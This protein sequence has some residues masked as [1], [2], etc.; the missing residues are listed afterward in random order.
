MYQIL[1]E[2]L[3]IH[4]PN[5]SQSLTRHS[6]RHFQDNLQTLSGHPPD[7]Q[8][9]PSKHSPDTLEIPPIHPLHLS[10]RK[11][12]ATGGLVG[13]INIM[14]RCGSNLQAGTCQILS[15]AENQRWS[16]VWKKMQTNLNE[17]NKCSV[18]AQ[19]LHEN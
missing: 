14:P 17:K 3:F 18:H 12:W 16:L 11:R 5:S 19:N 4:P 7:T 15:L 6:S 1:P 10:V 9:I 2:T 13:F 8:E